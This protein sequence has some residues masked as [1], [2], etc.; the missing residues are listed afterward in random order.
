MFSP[1]RRAEA[2][3]IARIS[4]AAVMWCPTGWYSLP[5]M[6]VPVAVAD[7]QPWLAGL[8]GSTRRARPTVGPG[9]D[10]DG[11]SGS[12]GG[13]RRVV[14]AARPG[15][16]R[17]AR[18]VLRSASRRGPLVGEPAAAG[19]GVHV[20]SWLSGMA[21]SVDACTAFRGAPAGSTRRNGRRAGRRELSPPD[22]AAPTTGVSCSLPSVRCGQRRWWQVRCSAAWVA[23]RIHTG[24]VTT[25]GD[26]D[27]G[28]LRPTSSG[29]AQSGAAAVGTYGPA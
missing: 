21:D 10:G 18:A 8:L 9:D 1:G 2:A 16:C 26:T 27:S 14:A 13:L 5:L 23:L 19:A 12:A 29:R 3:G 6:V 11:A 7:E 25:T 28:L 4:H 17:G 24:P 22:S 15:C 20:V